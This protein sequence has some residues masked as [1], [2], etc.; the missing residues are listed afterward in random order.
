MLIDDELKDH[1]PSKNFSS[2]TLTTKP[3]IL[4]KDLN[5]KDA[6]IRINSTEE[7]HIIRAESLYN[8]SYLI[9]L[10]CFKGVINFYYL[11]HPLVIKI[12]IV[13]LLDK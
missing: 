12:K 1:I 3:S 10:N 4:N 8:K 7:A 9:H 13:I 5:N 11:K 6:H 2:N